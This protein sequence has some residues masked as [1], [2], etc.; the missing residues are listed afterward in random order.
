MAD[1][2]GQ[3]CY[4]PV[5]NKTF[6]SS[7][8]SNKADDKAK[9]SEQIKT[10]FIVTGSDVSNTKTKDEQSNKHNGEFLLLFPAFAPST[11]FVFEVEMLELF[12]DSQT[13]QFFPK[14]K[15]GSDFHI[16]RSRYYFGHLFRVELFSISNPKQSIIETTVKAELVDFIAARSNCGKWKFEKEENILK[17]KLY[18]EFSKETAKT[19]WS[20][21]LA[22][23]KRDKSWKVSIIS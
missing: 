21:K 23:E 14:K 6:T 16:K 11:C 1:R 17:H 4:E 18:N 3:R 20:N 15:N 5:E 8:L 2:Q 19:F 7:A 22:D 12:M 9:A 13:K 10:L